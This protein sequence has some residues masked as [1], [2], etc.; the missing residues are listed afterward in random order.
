MAV[1]ENTTLGPGFS[2][3]DGD[4]FIN[5]QIYATSYFGVGSVFVNSSFHCCCE[6][7]YYSN[8]WSQVGEGSVVD[9]GTWNCVAFGANNTLHP[10]GGAAFSM[11]PG[12]TIA[13]PP[14]MGGLIAGA[15][16]SADGQIIT[17]IERLEL[18]KGGVIC[19]CSQGRWDREVLEKGYMIIGDDGTATVTVER[20]VIVCR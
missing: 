1:Y 14:Q 4:I 15:E 2:G 19:S 5:V 18:E 11:G 3:Q 17:P 12:S 9:G 8:P 20:A 13:A 10:G 6:Y 7:N 16:Y